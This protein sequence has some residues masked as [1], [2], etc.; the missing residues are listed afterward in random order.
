MKEKREMATLLRESVQVN[1]VISCEAFAFGRRSVRD[2][3]ISVG[4]KAVYTPGDEEKL[5]VDASDPSRQKALFL[6]TAVDGKNA[7][8]VRLDDGLDFTS[9][10]A[11]RIAFTFDEAADNAVKSIEL[12][13]VGL[14]SKTI[15][16]GAVIRSGRFAEKNIRKSGNGLIGENDR[17]LVTAIKMEGG[18]SHG[19]YDVIP[20]GHCIYAVRLDENN[21]YGAE[22][23]RVKFYMSGDFCKEFSLE[24]VLLAGEEPRELPPKTVKVPVVDLDLAS[25][26]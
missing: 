10:N 14:T 2:G 8:A 11:E 18:G 6:V 26:V 3:R 7:E 4:Y 20:D 17:F 16:E 15:K 19:M 21:S 22:S 24:V 12:K 9:Y 5:V 23:P 1:H 25:V 13:G